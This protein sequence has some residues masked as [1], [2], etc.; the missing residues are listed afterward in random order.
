MVYL[1]VTGQLVDPLEFITR[2]TGDWTCT[3]CA[4]RWR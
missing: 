1:T 3:S 4:S 2:G